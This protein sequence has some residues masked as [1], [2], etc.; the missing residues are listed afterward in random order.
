[1]TKLKGLHFAVVVLMALALVP[2]GAHLLALPNKIDL[3]QRDY[4]TVQAIYL[5]W[6]LPSGIILVSAIVTRPDADHPSARLRNAVLASS[7]RLRLDRLDACHLLCLDTA[8]QRGHRQL[9]RRTGRLAGPPRPVGV[10]P[11][12]Q[13]GGD[14]RRIVRGAGSDV[15]GPWRAHRRTSA[16]R[17][18]PAGIG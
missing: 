11:R 9:D 3:P 7:S 12:H 14:T 10:L 17:G 15:D 4:F 6:W 2:V 18:E 1:M 16:R 8:G 5:G 13:C